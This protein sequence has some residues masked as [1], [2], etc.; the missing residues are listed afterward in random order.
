MG[1][2]RQEYW[3]GLH[4]LLQE[5]LLTQGSNPGLLVWQVDSLPLHHL[6]SPPLNSA[7]SLQSCPTLRPHRR[8]PTRLP[9]PW[10]S[11]GKNTGVGCHFLLQEIFPT[12]GSNRGLPHCRQMLYHLSHQGSSDFHKLDI[13][14]EYRHLVASISTACRPRVAFVRIIKIC[15]LGTE[16]RVL[17]F[18]GS[19]GHGS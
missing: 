10:D 6:G 2:P 9:C 8:Q 3:N 7:K 19:A 15:H 11:P 18:L 1:F 12:Q 4:F 13:L 5:I 16:I 14:V 17:W